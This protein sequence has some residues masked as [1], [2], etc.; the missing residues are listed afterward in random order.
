[1]RSVYFRFSS[2]FVVLAL[3]IFQLANSSGPA[4]N[5]NYFTG[6]PTASGG[7]ERTCS[8]CHS[9]GSFGEP[10]I[11]VRFAADGEPA[12]TLSNYRPGQTYTVTLAVG[13]STAAPAG[14]G[15]QS[16]F[17]T[18]AN[19][20][21]GTLDMPGDGVQITAGNG[22][23]RYAEHSDIN[24]DSTFTFQWT[25]PE[26]GAGEVKLYAVGNLVNRAN[27]TGGDNGSTAPTIITLGEGSPVATREVEAINGALFPNP[28][29]DRVFLDIAPRVAGTYTLQLLAVDGRPLGQ[30]TQVLRAGRQRLELP[31]AQ[32][33]AGV[34]LVT[35][36]GAGG[37]FA[38][39]IVKE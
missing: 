9:G 18:A 27:G 33:P 7:T 13:Y 30:S 4:A 5:G 29:A 19:A 15:F 34:Y 12:D 20:T 32:A 23:R 3:A 17:L 11:S 22:D 38:G 39:R 1:M 28:A 31:L 26:A 16:Q 37:R 8:T 35:L 6:A 36:T 21:A 25:A 10:R 14:Y 2:L 24:S